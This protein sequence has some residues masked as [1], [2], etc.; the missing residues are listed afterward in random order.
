[1]SQFI[2]PL[3]AYFFIASFAI[4]ARGGEHQAREPDIAASPIP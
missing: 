1:M 2:V 3:A 4:A